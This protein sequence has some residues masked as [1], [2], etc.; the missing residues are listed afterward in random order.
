LKL[1][2][3]DLVVLDE[4]GACY[5]IRIRGGKAKLAALFK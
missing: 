1:A 4:K 2:K 5:W 3:D